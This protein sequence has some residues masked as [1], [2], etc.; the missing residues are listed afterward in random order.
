MQYPQPDIKLIYQ[1]IRA[2][3]G[4]G[5][6]TCAR[7]FVAANLIDKLR[8]GQYKNNGDKDFEHVSSFLWIQAVSEFRA[9]IDESTLSPDNDIWTTNTMLN[10]MTGGFDQKAVAGD[11]CLQ[12]TSCHEWVM[13]LGESM[14]GFYYGLLESAVK[15][16]EECCKHVKLMEKGLVEG[17]DPLNCVSTIRDVISHHPSSEAF[18]A[19]T[20]DV[21]QLAVAV[22]KYF[23][24]L[25]GIKALR[26][27]YR[28]PKQDHMGRTFDFE[29]EFVLERCG[30]YCDMLAAAEDELRKM[31]LGSYFGGGRGHWNKFWFYGQCGEWNRAAAA[32]RRAIPAADE[33]GVEDDFVSGKARF[34][35]CGA[36]MAG[37][38]GE[39]YKMCD[40]V[41]VFT[42]GETYIAKLKSLAMD[43]F[44]PGECQCYYLAQDTVRRFT[45]ER[46]NPNASIPA[47]PPNNPIDRGQ[48][49][50]KG[51]G[52]NKPLDQCNACSKHVSSAVKMLLCSR[53]KKVAYCSVDCQ[54]ADFKGHKGFCKANAVPAQSN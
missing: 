28:L 48:K 53:C 32:L 20:A 33:A 8:N 1:K 25:I 7:F 11:P 30:F 10:R 18:T 15:G 49:L 13:L 5:S 40:I 43:C 4:K 47:M 45:Q 6:P 46:G 21:T 23:L 14:K 39:S 42:A 35:L 52:G 26:A 12:L 9:P 27:V 16:I 41:S 29:R 34:D 24:G 31:N 19:G 2:S 22:M 36:L 38:E 54:R 50:N 44:V 17:R 51:S 3:N 37:G